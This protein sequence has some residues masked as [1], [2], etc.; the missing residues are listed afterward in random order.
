VIKVN[1]NGEWEN[2]PSTV[3]IIDIHAHQ[4]QN[5]GLC[6]LYLAIG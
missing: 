6:W 5:D 1:N 3:C 4:S 2:S